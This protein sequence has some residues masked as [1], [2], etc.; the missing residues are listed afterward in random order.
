MVLIRGALTWDEDR[1]VHKLTAAK[2]LP[3]A[4]AREQLARSVHLR[5]RSAGLQPEQ[6]ED[7][8]AVCE[9]F[10]G[11]CSLVVHVAAARPDPLDIVSDRYHISPAAEC[12]D[13]L[14]AFAGPGNVWLSAKAQG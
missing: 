14:R 10:P 12:F 4:G 8:Q 13:R 2:V 7:L 3:L 11:T 5:L 1:R 9:A 6:L